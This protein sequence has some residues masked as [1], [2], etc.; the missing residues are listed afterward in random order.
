MAPQIR[1]KFIGIVA[2]TLIVVAILAVLAMLRAPI[3]L[4]SSLWLKAHSKPALLV[5][6]ETLDI[7]KF[8]E[9]YQD[10]LSYQRAQLAPDERMDFE[11]SL[12]G[13]EGAYYQLALRS[14]LVED[15]TRRLLLQQAAQKQ[16]IR[17]TQEE[18]LLA[19]RPQ[20]RRFLEQNGVPPDQIQKTLEDAKT[21]QSAFT[22]NLLEQTRWQLLT[23]RLQERVVGSL[24][25]TDGE[26]RTYFQ[27][28]SWRYYLPELVHVRHILIRV[29]EGATK[30]MLEAARRK[31][32]EIRDQ[33]EEGAIFAQLA[34]QYSED[35][36]TASSG[37]DYGWIQRGDPAGEAFVEAAFA[38]RSPG[39]VSE[40]VQSKKGFH[41]I[42]LLERRPARGETLED[43]RDEVRRDYISEQTQA[44]FKNWYDEYRS[45]ADVRLELPLL[46]AYRLESQDRQAALQAYEKIQSQGSEN[47]PY[48]GYY[49]A[50]LYQQDLEES[51]QELDHLQQSGGRSE[52][53]TQ[54][55]SKV[56]GLRLRIAKNLKDV[57]A[58][59]QLAQE[60]YESILELTPEDV[61]TRF[62]FA[63][64]LIRQGL[65]DQAAKH[66]NLVLQAQPT[67]HQALSTY[68]QLLLKMHRYQEAVEP[69]E[70]ALAADGQ[71]STQERL[72]LQLQ[73]AQ[74]YTELG[75]R[76]EARRLLQGILSA[77]PQQVEANRQLGLLA[78][79]QGQYRQAIEYW[80]TTL[81]NAAQ[82]E[83]AALQVLL[84]QAYVGM[85]DLEQAR[86]SFQQ[87]LQAASPPEE[88]YR[89][90]GELSERQGNVESALGYYREGL[91]HA[92]GWEEKEKL[93][94][95]VLQLAPNDLEARFT[96]ARLYEV[97][98]RYA[99]AME[100]YR[101]ILE[102]QRDSLAAWRSLG[103][104]YLT[105]QQYSDALQTFQQALVWATNPEEQA[106][107]WARILNVDR[108]QSK[109][110]RTKTGLEALYQLAKLSLQMGRDQ[111]S[112][113]QIA[114][115]VAADPSYRTEEVAHLI[116]QLRQKGLNV[117]L[118]QKRP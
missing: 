13:A 31:I 117:T 38:L 10:F 61:D 7:V 55:Q 62:Q 114:Q 16:G 8:E 4:L 94:T 27:E 102:L 85:G 82:G 54:L 83:K 3:P 52:Q 107:L 113:D 9:A 95:L 91:R 39:D 69:L 70:R 2:S 53:I 111:T 24:E 28:R 72:S 75:R 106:G 103:D 71:E 88:T 26:L 84:G 5:N 65:W 64:F 104:I 17:I 43:V 35:T 109:N 90:L 36:T 21:Y 47:D 77:Q 93:A 66:L 11:R 87:A 112:A 41:L 49:I 33:W 118:P 56:Q 110:K 6:G 32:T 67:S 89:H 79:Q 44:R 96:L 15:L 100:Q 45:Q 97:Q 92:I 99:E 116:E 63:Q 80:Q 81:K 115:L 25:P 98:K 105:L 76:E 86:K 51:E 108:S 42:Q 68:G 19:V 18:L 46:V 101:A 48:L 14:Q 78:L 23:D 34:R 73:L 12:L 58:K 22:Q 37:G 60:F 57:L 59:G 20:L 29:S 50:R 40:P 1:K 30:D 74:T